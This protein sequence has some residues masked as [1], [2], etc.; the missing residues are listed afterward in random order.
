MTSPQPRP[1]VGLTCCLRLLDVT[2][3]HMV[4]VKYVNAAVEGVGAVPVL[5]PALA[6]AVPPEAML[7]RLDGLLLTGSPSNI[8]PRHYEGHPPR[9]DSPADP[10]RDA[11]TFGLIRAALAAGMPVLGICRGMQ[12][13]NV[14]LGGSLEQEVHRVPGR[15]DHRSPHEGT[16]DY[17]YR[18]VHP[19]RLT[20][21]GT[22]ARLAG[23]PELMVNSLHEQGIERL[24]PGL[25]VEAVAPDG[26]IEAVRL[27]GDAFVLGI[28]WHPEWSLDA[29]FSRRLFA[30]FGEA[31]RRYRAGRS[32]A[33]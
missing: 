28:Q 33:F 25:A 12:E 26:Q 16:P 20:E 5:L 31:C 18:P 27:E 17:R 1:H 24:A 13:L 7:E 19:V 6:G 23:E 14:V 21:G 3:F 15:M 11:T 29:P 8:D 30:A 32:R 2:P 10:A 9:E 22:C 4:A